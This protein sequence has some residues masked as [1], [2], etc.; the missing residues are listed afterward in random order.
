MLINLTPHPIHILDENNQVILT[1]PSSGELRLRERTVRAGEIVVDGIRI[2]IVLKS[3][4]PD[5]ELPPQKDGTFYI[6][7]LPVAQSVIR[8]D[9]LV[10]DQVVRGPDGN[11]I[12]CRRLAFLERT[13]MGGPD[14]DH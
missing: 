2:E 8:P 7:S 12:G 5:V 3:L 6:V 11:I 9:F 1:I 14:A 10:P 4:S 13:A